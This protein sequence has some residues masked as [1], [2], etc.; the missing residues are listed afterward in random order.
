MTVGVVSL[1]STVT[2]VGVV[3][4]V[5]ITISLFVESTASF[6]FTSVDVA[7]TA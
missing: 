2:T 4:A 7:T 5:S 6:P 1:V 3:I